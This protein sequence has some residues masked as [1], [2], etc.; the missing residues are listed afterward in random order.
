M[1]S[2]KEKNE[3][4]W[5]TT[6]RAI[7]SIIAVPHSLSLHGIFFKKSKKKRKKN[8]LT[9]LLLAHH[10]HTQKGRMR[11][12]RALAMSNTHTQEKTKRNYLGVTTSSHQ[13]Q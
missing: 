8:L 2:G 12:S 5:P 13:T 9:F 11:D 3:L 4:E 7:T 10:R 6:A 1:F